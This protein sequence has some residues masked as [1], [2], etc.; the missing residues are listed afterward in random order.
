MSDIKHSD[1]LV[2]YLDGNFHQSLPRG[3]NDPNRARQAAEALF[4]P[5]QQIENPTNPDA[6]R[7]AQQGQRKP[8]IL[9]AVREQQPKGHLADHIKQ[10]W[11]GKQ[12]APWIITHLDC[13]RAFGN[14]A[15]HFSDYVTY[16]PR[17]LHDDDLVPILASMQR[18]IAFF[19]TRH[20]SA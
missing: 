4:A 18:V 16:R 2:G 12:I 6:T 15:V 19:L 1:C 10:L 5:R 11:Q 8:R 13:L 3:H 7:R 20:C 14:E 17:R 9:S